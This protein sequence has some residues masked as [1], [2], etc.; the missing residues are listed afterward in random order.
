[1]EVG[2]LFCIA[3]FSGHGFQQAPAAGRGL[4][5]LI[6]HG[7]FLTLD[8]SPLTPARFA[9]GALLREEAVI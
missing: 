9:T 3:G 1:P 4:A 8:L 2:G 7:R 5:E 6:R